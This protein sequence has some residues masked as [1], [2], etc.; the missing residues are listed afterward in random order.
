MELTDKQQ[1][2]LMDEV[3]EID[4]KLKELDK[5]F[6]AFCDEN[7]CYDNEIFLAEWRKYCDKS[8]LLLATRKELLLKLF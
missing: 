3:I 8:N 6:K 2:E 4:F 7:F 5:T 1:Q